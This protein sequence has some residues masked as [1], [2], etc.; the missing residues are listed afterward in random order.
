MEEDDRASSDA[1]AIVLQRSLK[2]RARRRA[3][4]RSRSNAASV[5]QR[6][7]RKH[8]VT[9]NC[10]VCPIARSAVSG[11]DRYVL[12]E[13]SGHRYAF[14]RERLAQ[15][16]MVSHRFINPVTR[17]EID[18]AQLR[19]LAA[20]LDVG[21]AR[22]LLHEHADREQLWNEAQGREGVMEYLSNSAEDMLYTLLRMTSSVDESTQ[23]DID[24]AFD[25]YGSL[26][27]DAVSTD[28]DRAQALVRHHMR[29]S[30]R[31][32][33]QAVMSQRRELVRARLWLVHSGILRPFVGVRYQWGV[34]DLLAV[35][36]E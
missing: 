18:E 27:W 26:I 33:G 25:E 16:Y 5:I 20:G 21:T 9:C 29:Y 28:R 19:E 32:L 14:S 17:R 7:L 3:L 35:P 34:V 4:H 13:P 11:G 8:L 22:G 23:G 30:R 36:V 1:A 12:T 15:Y 31:C 6:Y 10:G 2:R 24:S